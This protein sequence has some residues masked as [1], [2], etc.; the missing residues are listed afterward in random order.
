MKKKIIYFILTFFFII[1][2]TNAE[3]C[4][5][6]TGTGKNLGDE[7]AC[8]T[9]HF[10]IVSNDGKI[11]R[12][13]AKYNL[14][15]G[16]DYLKIDLDNING[17]SPDV[18][19]TDSKVQKAIKNGYYNLY[20][21]S[22]DL[23]NSIYTC[24]Q[25]I[26][27]RSSTDLSQIVFFDNPVSS[28]HEALK[29][30]EVKKILDS[31]YEFYASYEYNNLIY[32]T[33]F[34]NENPDIYDYKTIIFDTNSK[35]TYT[36]VY[37]KKEVRELLDDGY[38]FYKMYG[39][40]PYWCE[41][42]RCTGDI[43]GVE[44]YKDYRY[45]IVNIFTDDFYSNT[46]DIT[47]YLTNNNDEYNRLLKDGYTLKNY[48]YTY[49]TAY[50]GSTNRIY[51]YYTGVT[52]SKKVKDIE[53]YN[54]QQ[55]ELAIGAHGD[56]IG[57]PASEEIGVVHSG[58]LWGSWENGTVYEEGYIDSILEYDAD[59]Y[60]NAYYNK[61]LNSGF[62]IIEVNIP[63]VA[64]INKFTKTLTKQYLPLLDWWGEWQ[65][66][67]SDML[68]AEYY[69][70][71]SIK[72]HIPNDYSWLWS[73]TYWTRTWEPAGDYI[74]FVDTLGN[75]CS[76]QYCAA[77]IGA[78]IRPLVTISSND[79]AYTI[80]TK[81]D[82]NGTIK[83]STDIGYSGDKVTFTITPEKGYV[84][85]IIKVIDGDGNIIKFTDNTFTMPSS[86]VIIEATFVLEN[87]NTSTMTLL[88]TSCLIIIAIGFY[89]T[90][91]NV[92]KVKWIN[93]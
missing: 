8:G 17:S 46:S 49:G 64:D 14:L 70:V 50:T 89:L 57:K 72:E 71:G 4:T 69:I 16:T 66:V 79:I 80:T 29:S 53:Y 39:S 74:Y 54:I 38:V 76:A 13:L 15:V 35:M 42:G 2:I 12:M 86:N 22:C 68:N 19:Y 34:I 6:V 65:E 55:N 32:G 27:T 11:A 33:S 62:N 36:D 7:I 93:N 44:L 87:P 37:E 10:Y 59:D 48:I 63:T 51:T 1:S 18:V 5:V 25:V 20:D 24:N 61:L 41:D 81:T 60:L 90:L 67:T 75:L 82:G 23:E 45:D 77:A 78:G 26:L 58:R 43:Y 3:K 31:G 9:E 40:T 73:T 21:Y 56:T 30:D 91:K 88:I 92:K 83:S 52:L 84:L 28:L 47:N 85:G